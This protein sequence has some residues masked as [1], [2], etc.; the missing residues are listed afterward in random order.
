MKTCKATES[1]WNESKI[2]SAVLF[3]YSSLHV[4]LRD[5]QPKHAWTSSCTSVVFQGKCQNETKHQR[6]EKSL[7]IQGRFQV[8]IIMK[9]IASISVSICLVNARKWKGERVM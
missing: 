1:L 2:F 5:K 4:C 8:V 9:G 3:C 6:R 7:L